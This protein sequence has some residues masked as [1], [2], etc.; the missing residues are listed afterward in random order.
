MYMYVLIKKYLNKI[1]FFKNIF[2]FF[3]EMWYFFLVG[4]KLGFCK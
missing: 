3:V 1:L 4:E 2:M